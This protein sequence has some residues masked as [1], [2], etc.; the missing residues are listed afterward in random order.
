MAMETQSIQAELN[1]VQSMAVSHPIAVSDPYL[2]SSFIFLAFK[3][4]VNVE[5]TVHFGH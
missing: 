4:E 2:T 1:R 5:R 3:V